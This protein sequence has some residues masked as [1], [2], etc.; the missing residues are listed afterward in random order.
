MN[1]AANND[2]NKKRIGEAGGIAVILRMLDV[3]GASNADVAE[4]GCGALLNLADNADNKNR[5]GEAGGIAMILRMLEVHG[6]SNAG[7]AKQGCGALYN[8]TCN[9]DDN[10]KRIGEAGGIAM[11]LRMLDVQGAS[12][13]GVAEYGCGALWNLAANADNK[14]K[15]LAANGVS[16]V[17]RMKSTWASNADVQK[18]ANG[19][20]GSFGISK[21]FFLKSPLS[22]QVGSLFSGTGTSIYSRSIP[23]LSRSQLP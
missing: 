20:L 1:L 9:N 3:Q 8:V 21:F 6:V 5:I 17:E 14:R 16:M 13:A 22:L 12:N 23:A 2:D 18:E 4:K 15:I 19:A 11:I 10:K 7:V